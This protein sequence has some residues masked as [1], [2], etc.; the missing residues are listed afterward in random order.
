MRPIRPLSALGIIL[1]LM[2]ASFSGCA[3]GLSSAPVSSPALTYSPTLLPAASSTPVPSNTPTPTQLPSST[4]TPSATATSSVTPTPTLTPTRSLSYNMPGV[5]T[6]GRCK[7]FQL[8]YS[9]PGGGSQTYT[10]TV[11]LCVTTVLVRD[12]YKLQFNVV[13]HFASTDVPTPHRYVYGHMDA[14]H[15]TDDLGNRY[16]PLA[17]SGQAPDN[18]EPGF[19][20]NSTGGWYLFSRPAKG[21][22]AFVLHDDDRKVDI[23]FIILVYR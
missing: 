22:R 11:N 18:D 12:D 13:Y 23:P 20:H 14:V 4:F 2:A 10:G 15:L 9:D 8:E 21:A 7:D 5:Y 6:I 16:D 17:D 3:S 19:G 1:G